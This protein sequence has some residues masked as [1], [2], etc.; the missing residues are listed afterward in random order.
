MEKAKRIGGH[1]LLAQGVVRYEDDFIH[2][3]LPLREVQAERAT[4]ELAPAGLQRRRIVEEDLQD[5]MFT[6]V[7]QEADLER[8]WRSESRMTGEIRRLAGELLV[9][10][11]ENEALRAEAM[12]A[13]MS[14]RA[15][16]ENQCHALQA[17]VKRLLGGK[18]ELEERMAF[19]EEEFNEVGETH[20]HDRELLRDEMAQAL[21]DADSKGIQLKLLGASFV[22]ERMRRMVEVASC[23]TARSVF[24]EWHVFSLRSQAHKDKQAMSIASRDAEST[25]MTGS[26]QGGL[27][28]LK[29]LMKRRRHQTLMRSLHNMERNRALCRLRTADPNPTHCNRTVNPNPNPKVPHGKSR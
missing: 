26:K 19:L 11:E 1:K 20:A 4:D 28:I 21:T 3:G 12:E 9:S 5:A 29:Q 15:S 6:S 18:A 27:E 23:D 24:Y 7:V 16:R 14:G 13:S 25:I 2:S 8:S 17:Q 22:A 10:R